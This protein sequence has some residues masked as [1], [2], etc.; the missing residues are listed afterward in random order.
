MK[1][2]STTGTYYVDHF[3]TLDS[4]PKVLGWAYNDF[5][6]ALGL[7]NNTIAMLQW[8]SATSKFFHNQ[9]IITTHTGGVTKLRGTRNRIYTLGGSDTVL[10]IY[11]LN[12]TTGVWTGNHSVSNVGALGD[13]AS[14][15]AVSGNEKRVAVGRSNGN[16]YMLGHPDNNYSFIVDQTL[17]TIHTNSVYFIR[18]TSN[19]W[20]MVSGASGNENIQLTTK[21]NNWATPVTYLYNG[22]NG[23]WDNVNNQFVIGLNGNTSG[24]F[25]GQLLQASACTVSVNGTDNTRCNCPAGQVWAQGRCLTLD[26]T[27]TLIGKNYNGAN[28]TTACLCNAGYKW[29]ETSL[30]CIKNCDPLV[31]AHSTEKNFEFLSCECVG[32]YQWDY[33]TST[34]TGYQNCTGMANSNGSNLNSNACYCNDGYVWNSTWT[35]ANN[36]GNVNGGACQVDCTKLPNTNNFNGATH[37]SCGCI[38]GFTWNVTWPARGACQRVC[39]PYTHWDLNTNPTTTTCSCTPGYDWTVSSTSC[40]LNCSTLPY[41]VGVAKNAGCKCASNYRWDSAVGYCV[42]KKSNT[43]VVL[44]CAI[45]IPLGVLALAALAGLLWFCCRPAPVPMMMPQPMMQSMVP[46]AAPVVTSRVVSPVT[47]QVVA[48]PAA[49]TFVQA[50]QMT[51]MTRLVPNGATGINSFAVGGG[52]GF[53]TP[54]AGTSYVGQ[55][56]IGQTSG[57]P[58]NRF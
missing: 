10:N 33:G 50:P 35:A 2:N 7:T 9:T 39:T 36:G 46:V 40:V 44:G 8:N 48:R 12:T 16:I 29:D 5:T 45:G 56:L 47:T 51:S 43:S 53:G 52:N 28:G 30:V 57:I 3:V 21:A 34:C 23:D 37:L 27:S 18:I 19:G 26:C 24:A 31:T 32:G 11:W 13:T 41:G 4:Q 38:S 55:G 25:T 1:K 49:K 22:R 6:L 14:A 15:L 42:S 17:T 54:I 58:V 20:H